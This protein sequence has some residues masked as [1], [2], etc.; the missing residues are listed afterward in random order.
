LEEIAAQ[1]TSVVPEHPIVNEVISSST[2][3]LT[4]QTI[5][6]PVGV[7]Y[8]VNMTMKLLSGNRVPFNMI[9]GDGSLVESYIPV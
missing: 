6:I 5:G 7:P 8:G 1:K 2:P 9:V 4:T 3:L